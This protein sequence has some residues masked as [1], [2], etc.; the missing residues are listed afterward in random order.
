MAVLCVVVAA[1]YLF[2]M[3]AETKSHNAVFDVAA[4]HVQWNS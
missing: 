1:F 2:A 3:A 4:L